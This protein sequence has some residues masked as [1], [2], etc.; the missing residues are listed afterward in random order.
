[1]DRRSPLAH[2]PLPHKFLREL[3]FLTMYEVRSESGWQLLVE[4]GTP[5]GVDVSA[6]RTC[7]E[8]AGPHALDVLEH[9]C[10]LDLHPDVFAVGAVAHTNLAKA[11][12]VLHRTEDSAYRIYVRSSYA[13]YLCRWLMD[14]MTEYP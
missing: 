2:L 9:G 4:P 10:S 12:V 11:Q 7:L 6:A 8:L 13:D 5:Q 1:M 3:P 14:A